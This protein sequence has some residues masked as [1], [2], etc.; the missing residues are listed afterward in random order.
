MAGKLNLEV[1]DTVNRAEDT[2]VLTQEALEEEKLGAF[3]AGY[4]AGWD[5]AAAADRETQ[6]RIRADLARGLRDLDLRYHEAHG[7][8]LQALMP[9]L[10]EMTTA[11]VPAVAAQ[12]LAPMIAERV[13]ALAGTMLD[14]PL[15]IAV[16]PAVVPAVRALI[17]A[18]APGAFTV[19]QDPLLNEGQAHL[20]IGET[21]ERIDLGA[22]T[23]AIQAA[24]ADYFAAPQDT[25]QQKDPEDG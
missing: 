25:T 17:E 23:A 24:V 21:E 10:A 1:F 22:V 14:Q 19:V 9:L 12:S 8:V 4:K 5:D 16:N 2:V 3:E 11:I 15:R 18:E 13:F 6:T 20:H 7:A